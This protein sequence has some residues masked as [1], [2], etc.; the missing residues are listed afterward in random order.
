LIEAMTEP[1]ISG[2]AD[3][4][5]SKQSRMKACAARP[6]VN[7]LF[8][9]IAHIEQHLDGVIAVRRSLLDSL[10]FDCD[11]GVD[12]GLLIDTA[13]SGMAI[14][15]VDVGNLEYDLQPLENLQD[16][17]TQFYRSL[18]TRAVHYRRLGETTAKYILN[19]YPQQ[20]QEFP[21]LLEQA[22]HPQRIA[23]IDLDHVLLETPLI[24]QVARRV[25]PAM[26][27]PNEVVGPCLAQE[28]NMSMIATFCRGSSRITLE[29]IAQSLPLRS[30]AK[31]I[32][33]GLHGAGYRVG[34]ISNGFQTI[35]DIIRRRILADFSIT[36]V[37]KYHQE[38]ATGN[39]IPAPAM[40]HPSGCH[41]HSF[42]RKNILA[43]VCERM[44]TRPEQ[45][46][47]IG[48][49]RHDTCLLRAAGRSIGFQPETID[50]RDAAEVTC[51][52][53][54]GDLL[55]EVRKLKSNGNG[56]IDRMT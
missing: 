18:L 7:S 34:L 16:V 31:E 43:H 20:S 21:F 36:N 45:V 41:L 51:S 47:V 22:K 46:L 3:Y 12:I 14:A 33:T 17:I 19:A 24:V 49:G 13:L 37:M 8:P 27:L 23:L 1:L 10:P 35:A 40:S 29:K 30:G 2:K 56:F 44:L 6:L 26:K 38:I 55:P 50:V 32:V 39:I 15:E 54:L 5:K 52:T 25:I 48:G 53:T 4:V 42:C 28:A 11:Y 9:E